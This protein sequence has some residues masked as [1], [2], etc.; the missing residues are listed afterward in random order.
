M[1][2]KTALSGI[3]GYLEYLQES[4]CLEFN[5]GHCSFSI[6][7]SVFCIC[8][9]NTVTLTFYMNNKLII[10][11]NYE[12][13]FILNKHN[14]KFITPI[15]KGFFHL[16]CNN[17]KVTLDKLSGL[18]RSP[19][20]PLLRKTYSVH[21]NVICSWRLTAFTTMSSA[22]EDLPRSPQ[23]H[24]LVNFPH[25]PQWHLLVKTYRVHH[26]VICS[27]RLTAFTTMS[28]AH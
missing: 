19:Q 26:N 3:S 22:C 18:P 9:L 10:S 7:G 27:L 28:S 25:S 13:I 24:L 8:V 11:S 21:H 16:G 1:L 14:L 12:N 4:M 2:H 23:C 6:S 5:K 20:C 15:R 17:N